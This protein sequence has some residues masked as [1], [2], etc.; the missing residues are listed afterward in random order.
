MSLKTQGA[1]RAQ[2]ELERRRKAAADALELEA[3][4][5]SFDE[6]DRPTRPELEPVR[7]KPK[8]DK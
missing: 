5:H 8:A 6:Y 4:R 2:L 3:A 7:P 1:K